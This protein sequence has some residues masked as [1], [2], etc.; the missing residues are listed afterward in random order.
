MTTTAVKTIR[1]LL[2]DLVNAS[3]RREF[4]EHFGS[5]G[6]G[7]QDTLDD[8]IKSIRREISNN[9]RTLLTEARHSDHLEHCE[10]I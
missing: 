10:C 5:H 9:I 6:D 4:Y 3:K 1:E 7:M 8:E 2:D